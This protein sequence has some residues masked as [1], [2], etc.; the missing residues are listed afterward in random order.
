MRFGQAEYGSEVVCKVVVLV[1]GEY[2]TYTGRTLEAVEAA[3][4]KKFPGSEIQVGKPV[5]VQR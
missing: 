2:A 3:L 1:D 5:W 4:S